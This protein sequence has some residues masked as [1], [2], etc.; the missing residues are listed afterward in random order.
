ML[1]HRK[2]WGRFLHILYYSLAFGI[3]CQ[4]LR[5]YYSHMSTMEGIEAVV[6]RMI[7]NSLKNKRGFGQ[8]SYASVLRSEPNL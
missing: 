8:K 5:R 6:S 3:K 7:S 2:D 4:V 1:P